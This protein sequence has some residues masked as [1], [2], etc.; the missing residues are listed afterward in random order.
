MHDFLELSDVIIST[1]F[2]IIVMYVIFD[3]RTHSMD[4]LQNLKLIKKETRTF[5]VST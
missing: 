4:L 3:K 2:L 1:E 5:G